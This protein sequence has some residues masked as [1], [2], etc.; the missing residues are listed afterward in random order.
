MREP[1]RRILPARRPAAGRIPGSIS[2]LWIHGS[3]GIGPA[4]SAVPRL[5]S[6][7]RA[8]R[9]GQH[10]D[11]KSRSHPDV[12]ADLDGTAIRGATEAGPTG[13]GPPCW[14]PS[15]SRQH[16]P[17][18]G[19]PDRRRAGRRPGRLP[20][21]R[22]ACRAGRLVLG[23]GPGLAAGPGHADPRPCHLVRVR[24]A[25]RAPS[26]RSCTRSADDGRCA[27]A[28]PGSSQNLTGD[29]SGF[30]PPGDIHRVR[31]YG[32]GRGHLA[33]CLR[34]RHLPAGQ[35]HPPGLR[36]AGTRARARLTERRAQSVP[37]SCPAPRAG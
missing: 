27:R 29:V 11:H 3:I 24:R 13:S 37:P 6:H 28:R 8:Q 31:N 33:A 23:D 9:G 25:S 10:D 2:A 36:P 30:A 5:N 20:L 4:G 7:R 26:T 19:D 1:R 21:P 12:P 35:Q 22:A 15:S 14:W 34:G 32:D 16:L 17:G 18:P